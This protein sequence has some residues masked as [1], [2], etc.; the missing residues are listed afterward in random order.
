M[1]DVVYSIVVAG[2]IGWSILFV[3]VL[4]W[5]YHRLTGRIK[6]TLWGEDDEN[7]R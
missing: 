1:S 3:S 5:E 6:A 7:N 4:L 2:V